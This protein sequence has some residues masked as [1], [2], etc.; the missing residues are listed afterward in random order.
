MCRLLGKSYNDDIKSE[1]EMNTMFKDRFGETSL[2]QC[3][4]M[5][6]DMT[7]SHTINNNVGDRLTGDV[8]FSATIMSR[9]VWPEVTHEEFKAPDM[10]EATM[11]QYSDAYST[12][13]RG[14]QSLKWMKSLGMVDIEIQLGDRTIPITGTLSF[15]FALSTTFSHNSYCLPLIV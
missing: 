6:R 12:S 4:A 9:E 13:K 5:L 11:K 14:K 1:T 7:V 8:K 2:H 10:I 15:T 3:Q